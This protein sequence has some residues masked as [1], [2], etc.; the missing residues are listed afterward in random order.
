MAKEQFQQELHAMLDSGS[1][2]L[3]FRQVLEGL[4][5]LIE[6]H[7]AVFTDISASYRLTAADSGISRAFE[8]KR[9]QYRPLGED[10]A[11]D[12]TISGKEQHLLAV[13]HK[14][15]NP[16]GALLTGKIKVKGSLAALNALAAY[17]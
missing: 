2:D 15:L 8:L 12:V 5:E 1:H 6:R 3:A 17:L 14:K 13:F 10:E 4:Q 7:S 11:A 9:G 16:A